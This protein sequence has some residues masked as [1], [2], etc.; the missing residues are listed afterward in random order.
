MSLLDLTAFNKALISFYNSLEVANYINE[1]NIT[2]NNLID[3]IKAG[4]I[5]NFE[6]TYELS[7][8]FIKRWLELNYGKNLVEG[9]TRRELFRIAAEN[10]LISDIE[11][12]M[13]YHRM[14][15]LTSYT[16]DQN[17]ADEIFSC[18]EIFYRDSLDLYNNIKHR[19]D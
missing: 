19:N 5:Q 10:K 14:R 8:K 2:D 18:T 17:V 4:V 3:T 9:T 7:W 6:F 16:Y 1:N 15:N 12:W 13:F 11:Q